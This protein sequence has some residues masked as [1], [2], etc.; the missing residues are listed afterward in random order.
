MEPSF[1]QRHRKIIILIG[2]IVGIILAVSGFLFIAL[3]IFGILAVTK[4][5][6]RNRRNM[7]DRS[8]DLGLLEPN[9]R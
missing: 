9:N 6:K 7:E 4:V 1:F 8:G 2:V 3:I 5:M